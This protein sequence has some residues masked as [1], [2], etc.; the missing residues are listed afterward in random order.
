MVRIPQI[1][2]GISFF[3]FGCSVVLKQSWYSDKY[4]FRFDFGEYHQIF[5]GLLIIFG[6][7]LIGITFKRKK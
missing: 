7:V 3:L 1:V 5:G 2:A 4:S 6:L